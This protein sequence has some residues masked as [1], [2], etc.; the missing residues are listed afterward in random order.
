MGKRHIKNAHMILAE[1]LNNKHH[2]QRFVTWIVYGDFHWTFFCGKINLARH[3][4]TKR[5]HLGNTCCSYCPLQ[6][7]F[8]LKLKKHQPNVTQ[9]SRN[10]S[11]QKNI[12]TNIKS[13]DMGT[14][15]V[16]PKE[17]IRFEWVKGVV[18]FSHFFGEKFDPLKFGYSSQF[19]IQKNCNHWI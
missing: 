19:V 1:G 5:I 17:T 11:F 4:Y 7:S 9:K 16:H 10:P 13:Y 15:L 12:C 3:G 14:G 18:R 6:T 2:Q 8:E